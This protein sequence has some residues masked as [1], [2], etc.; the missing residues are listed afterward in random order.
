MSILNAIMTKIQHLTAFLSDILL[1]VVCVFVCVFF[2]GG[3][4]INHSTFWLWGACRFIPRSLLPLIAVISCG[5]LP[6]PP[7]GKKIGTQTTFGATAIFTCNSG[8]ILV[9]STVRECL[10]SGLWSGTETHCLGNTTNLFSFRTSPLL[11]ITISVTF[12]RDGI[13]EQGPKKICGI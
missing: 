13:L 8:Y 9:G 2:G 6:T 11:G 7:N 1:I 3:A 5:E 10:A 4:G 12:S